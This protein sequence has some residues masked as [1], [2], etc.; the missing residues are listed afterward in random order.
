[1]SVSPYLLLVILC[2]AINPYI[3]SKTMSIGL[4][5]YE[6]FVAN[7]I[8]YG[9]VSFIVSYIF[10]K[11]FNT[12]F[13]DVFKKTVSSSLGKLAFAGIT[14][15]GITQTLSLIQ[16][17]KGGEFSKVVPYYMP[18]VLLLQTLFL[19]P[20]DKVIYLGMGMIISGF[21][22]VSRRTQLLK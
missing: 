6:N 2:A 18:S 17:Y 1:M 14:F 5:P 16:L 19:L 13:T 3:Y 15:T 8:W 9:I 12:S 10:I 7:S 4:S 22:I 21:F 11:K 20:Q